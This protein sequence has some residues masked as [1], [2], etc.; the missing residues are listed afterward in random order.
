M[1]AQPGTAPSTPERSAP[2]NKA[3]VG[4]FDRDAAAGGYLYTRGDRLSAVL[5]NERQTQ[6]ILQAADFKGR[7]VIDLGCGDGTYTLE[8]A[9]R[10]GAAF[11]LGIDP[12]AAA[13]ERATRSAKAACVECRFDV[14]SIY[15]LAVP[16]RFDVAVVRGVLHHLAEPAAAV[17]N[18]FRL[19]DTVVILEPNGINPVLK[20]IE[21]VSAYHREH[22]ERSF[23]PTRIDAWID[24]GGGRVTRRAF[25]TFVPFFCPA[26]LARV[27]KFCEPGVEALPVVR[28]IAA[29][30]YLVTARRR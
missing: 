4:V 24:A 22:E 3:N 2:A 17:A 27:L 7:R 29:G 30:Q 1:T 11:V 18:A 20:L 13:I 25:I 16:Q 28:W 21:R 10:S 5:A 8:L 9:R 14:G 23:L 15:D 6:G 12:A 19:A 26:A